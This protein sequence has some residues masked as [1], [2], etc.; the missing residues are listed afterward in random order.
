MTKEEHIEVW[1]WNI[2]NRTWNKT[3]SVKEIRIVKRLEGAWRH[4]EMLRDT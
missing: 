2:E 3:S 4:L 1:K